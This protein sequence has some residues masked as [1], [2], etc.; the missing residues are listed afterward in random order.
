MELTQEQ[1]ADFQ[2]NG[3]LAIEDAFSLAEWKR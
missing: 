3:V 2:R 1:L